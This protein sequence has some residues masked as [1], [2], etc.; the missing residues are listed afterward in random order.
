ML[1]LNVKL[2][3]EDVGHGIESLKQVTVFAIEFSDIFLSIKD[4][5]P[6]WLA[7]LKLIPF[8]AQ[9]PMIIAVLPLAEVE[10]N[11]LTIENR[12][13]LGE[14]VADKISSLKNIDAS[15]IEEVAMHAAVGLLHLF[16][17]ITELKKLKSK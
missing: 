12:Q 11:N 8:L 16:G 17:A 7:I 1:Q 9:L 10:L 2:Q 15:K 14:Y 5:R 3:K 13:K 6:R 4:S